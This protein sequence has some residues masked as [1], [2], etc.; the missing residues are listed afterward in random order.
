M[1][2]FIR[3]INMAVP[4]SDV[5]VCGDIFQFLL[6]FQKFFLIES[7]TYRKNYD[8][9]RSTKQ[10]TTENIHWACAYLWNRIFCNISTLFEQETK[11]PPQLFPI[12]FETLIFVFPVWMDTIRYDVA[13]H[14][15]HK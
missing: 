14:S 5:W 12:F 2:M 10:Y 9:E 8:V 3:F 7:S 4:S 1:E 15:C 11:S 6:W 13:A